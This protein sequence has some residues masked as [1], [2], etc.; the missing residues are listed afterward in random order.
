LQAA[1]LPKSQPEKTKMFDFTNEAE[2]EN[3]QRTFGEGVE[4]GENGDFTD[5]VF[6]NLDEIFDTVTPLLDSE[7]ESYD[8]GYHEGQRRR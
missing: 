4:D 7:H 8:A 2:T 5:D 6:Q 3:N 1:T